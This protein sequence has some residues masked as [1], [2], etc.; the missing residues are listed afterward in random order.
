[1]FEWRHI[2]DIL[3][4]AADLYPSV[5]GGYGLHIHEMSRRQAELGHNV[6]V[7]TTNVDSSPVKE[8]IHG[9]SVTRF[10]PYLKPMGNAILINMFPNLFRN[11]KSHDIIHAHSHLYFSTNLCAFVRKLGS[12]PLVIT[13]HGLN[14]Q[15]APEW[16]QKFYNATGARFTFSAADKIICYT[17]TEKEQVVDLGISPDK[18][19]V[20]H[21]GIDTDLFVPSTEN[22]LDK[23]HIL[24]VGRYAKGKGVNYL[25]DSFDILRN[26]HPDI[27]I[28]M[29]GRGPD[30]DEIVSKI[31][32]LGLDNAITMKDYIP[33][34]EIVDLYQ[35]CSLFVLSSLE[36]G[37]P[38]TIMEA[39]SCE[40]PVVCT[41]LPQLVDIVEGS[42]FLVP[43]KDAPALAEGMS[44]LLSD[45]DLAKKMGENGRQKV[46]SEHS[47]NDT[48]EKTIELYEG[49][50]RDV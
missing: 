11:R 21:N 34:S 45:I 23:K 14:S 39:M 19:D 2:L 8:T 32:S 27:S 41:R 7:Y 49:L 1:L 43:V 50:N 9:Y 42:G 44:K 10:F 33:N 16:F 35:S 28:T 12:S 25:I 47:W 40:L 18:I 30:K 20:I 29:V 22:N 31:N 36:E 46:V 6:S 26:E 4:V 5:V 24:W 48:V 13:N 17:E 3:R 37:V 38:R 15:T